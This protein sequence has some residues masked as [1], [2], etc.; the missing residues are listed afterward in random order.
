MRIYSSTNFSLSLKVFFNCLGRTKVRPTIFLFCLLLP[1]Q[2][3]AQQKKITHKARTT[4]V[5]PGLRR[6]FDAELAHISIELNPGWQAEEIEDPI[7]HI[8]QLLISDP[9]DSTKIASL[10][11]QRFESKGFDSIKWNGLKN[12]IRESYGN[13]GIALRPLNEQITSAQMRDSLG[14]IARY[15]LLAKYSDHLEYI[16]AVVGK[17]SLVLLTMPLESEAYRKK[18]G[19]YREIAG[20]IKLPECK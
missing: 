18:I 8:Y 2:G 14:V 1:L 3:F 13:R 4:V 16:N 12:S 19:Y 17:K 5:I 15:E 11:M 9:Y 20:S 7:E 10:L 6:E